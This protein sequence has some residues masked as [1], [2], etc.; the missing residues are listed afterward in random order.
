MTAAKVL[1]VLIFYSAI[2][3]ISVFFKRRYQVDYDRKT[4]LAGLLLVVVSM[5]A[6]QI[7]GFDKIFIIDD[8]ALIHVKIWRFILIVLGANAVVQL[9]MWLSYT[10]VTVNDIVK[11]PRFIFNIFALLIIVAIF[12][13]CLNKV[14]D[15]DLSGL[16]V[17]STVVSAVI[18]LS[19]QDTLTNLFAGVSLQ[20]E[21]P[22]NIDDWVNLG[23][24]EGKIVSQ[25]WRTLTL[26]TRENHRVS[27]PNKTVAEEKI[28]NYSRPTKRQIHSFFVDLDYS[29]PP[30]LVKKAISELLDEI[31]E[32]SIDH[33][34]YPYVVSYES[35]G[36]KYCLKYWIEDYADVITIQDI[37][38]SR[39][40]YKLRR[41]NIKIPYPTSEIHLELESPEAERRKSKEQVAYIRKELSKQEWLESIDEKQLEILAEG[42]S[43]MTYAK[44]DNLVT[45][46]E[47]GDSMFFIL[48]GCAK[49]FVKGTRGKEVYVADK[50]V[51]EYFGE[52]SLLTGDV[53]TATVRAVEDIEVIVIDKEH[54]T[55]IIAK[56]A[57]ILNS[58]VKALEKNQSSLTKIIEDEKNNS[59]IPMQSA[60]KIIMNKIIGYLNIT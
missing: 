23:G 28:I 25:N 37:V 41:N 50:G 57:E 36:I 1:G 47:E 17:T 58:L 48:H 13:Y 9:V 19:L 42:A 45:Q 6:W 59:K 22:F 12:L 55:D 56:D 24:Y 38:L 10:F 7:G 8:S 30:N 44:D 32:V 52:M 35:S 2:L 27:L 21:A 49:V 53:R 39:L 16:L 34:A 11:M 4:L 46:G 5:L 43:L 26:L 31:P 15:Q 14:F 3:F 40:W 51:G 20:I 18:G 33:R 60:R 54:F 29:H